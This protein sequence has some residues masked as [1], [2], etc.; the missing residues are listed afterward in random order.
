[1][2]NVVQLEQPDERVNQLIKWL[3]NALPGDKFKYF[4]GEYL[5]TGGVGRV[6]WQAYE[7]GVVTLYQKRNEYGKFEYWIER[8][9]KK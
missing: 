9:K 7:N 2:N 3:D 1:M 5:K 8:K 4:T 6:A